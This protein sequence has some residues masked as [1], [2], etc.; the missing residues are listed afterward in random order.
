[1]QKNTK[2]DKPH[3]VWRF[4]RIYMLTAAFMFMVG[5][6]GG[7]ALAYFKMVP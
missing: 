5:I 6:V 1:M 7:A 3:V 2:E 4:A